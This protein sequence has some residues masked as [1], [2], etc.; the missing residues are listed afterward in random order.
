MD[1]NS[2]IRN[3]ID[4]LTPLGLFKHQLRQCEAILG[5]FVRCSFDQ[6][7]AGHSRKHCN[8]SAICCTTISNTGHSVRQ[9]D[10]TAISKATHWAGAIDDTGSSE[11]EDG[12]IR[13][14]FS[15]R[16]CEQN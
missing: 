6:R 15:V 4:L 7:A 13:P 16:K 10:D 14:A 11:L 9:C 1:T 5:A 12:H 2:F 3:P 8:G